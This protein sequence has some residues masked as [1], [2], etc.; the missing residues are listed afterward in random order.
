MLSKFDNFTTPNAKRFAVVVMYAVIH[1]IRF[2]QT[3]VI[4][5][6]FCDIGIHIQFIANDYTLQI[7]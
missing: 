1:L 7:A 4:L 5:L 3:D 6:C 2:I